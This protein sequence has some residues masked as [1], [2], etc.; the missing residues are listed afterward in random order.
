MRSENERLLTLL[1]SKQEQTLMMPI[2]MFASAGEKFA[3]FGRLAEEM[4][5][6][7]RN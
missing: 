1:S 4:L 7:R 5:T 6:V 2:L 3:K